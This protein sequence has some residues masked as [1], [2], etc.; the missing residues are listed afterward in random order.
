MNFVNLTSFES[1][2][3]N[4]IINENREI[5]ILDSHK[6]ILDHFTS[7]ISTNTLSNSTVFRLPFNNPFNF[8]LSI[9]FNEFINKSAEDT[10]GNSIKTNDD[11]FNSKFTLYTNNQKL[12]NKLLNIDELRRLLLAYANKPNYPIYD[13]QISNWKN[14]T[15]LSTRECHGEIKLVV[16]DI[17]K[18]DI[19][20]KDCLNFLKVLINALTTTGILYL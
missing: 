6:I 11:I 10:Y 20:K 8:N 1:T 15:F 12:A 16:C 3:D 2:I 9:T 13:I 14:S 17:L 18:E 7:D 4:K 5:L 19:D